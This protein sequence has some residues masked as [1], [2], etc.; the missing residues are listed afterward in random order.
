MITVEKKGLFKTTRTQYPGD[1]FAVIA[2]GDLLI[3]GGDVCLYCI[4]ASEY[5]AV[6]V[7]DVKPTEQTEYAL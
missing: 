1:R 2:R 7:H 6:S 4:R 3:F 5:T